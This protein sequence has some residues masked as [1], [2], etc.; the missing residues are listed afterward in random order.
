MADNCKACERIISHTDYNCN[1]GYCDECRYDVQHRLRSY[2]DRLG[3]WGKAERAM[4][5]GD[6]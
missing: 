5:R 1:S 4:R 6:A 3:S 2:Y